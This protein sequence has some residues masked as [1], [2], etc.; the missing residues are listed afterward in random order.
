MGRTALHVAAHKG[1]LTMLS[2]LNS[3]QN[4]QPEIQ[5]KDGLTALHLATRGKSTVGLNYLL[6]S[7]IKSSLI[8]QRDANLRT[9]LSWAACVGSSSGIKLLLSMGAN[10]CLPDIEG[11]TPL[12]WAVRRSNN[13]KTVRL[14]LNS[15]S[16]LINWADHNGRTPLHLAISCGNVN[17]VKELMK[18]PV[19][20]VTRV[21]SLKTSKI[22]PQT[23]RKTVSMAN[24]KLPTLKI[25][26]DVLISDNAFRTILHCAAQVGDPDITKIILENS[27]NP[28][29]ILMATDSIGATPLHYAA[30]HDH[31]QIVNVL[32][33]NFNADITTFINQVDSDGRSALHWAATKGAMEGVSS[34]FWDF[35]GLFWVIYLIDF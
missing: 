22:S 14:I 5:D 31:I 9:P 19:A 26:A 20:K 29:K 8:D 21:S 25:K 6:T 3:R 13:A 10:P 4:L 27:S 7:V 12:H 23:N 34:F 28:N 30:Q 16:S 2:L 1:C 35:S 17:I 33:D 24:I 15:S 32:L 11:Q 18:T